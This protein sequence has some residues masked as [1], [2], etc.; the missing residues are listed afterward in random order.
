MGAKRQ[1]NHYNRIRNA[2][3]VDSHTL[4]SG[5]AEIETESIGR[6]EL[7]VC[8]IF[9][10]TKTICTNGWPLWSGTDSMSEWNSFISTF[11]IQDETILVV[12][13]VWW[14]STERWPSTTEWPK[15]KFEKCIAF[16][17]RAH[18]GLEK[19]SKRSS[20]LNRR[21]FGTILPRHCEMNRRTVANDFNDFTKHFHVSNCF[22]RLPFL[23]AAWTNLTCFQHISRRRIF[24]AMQ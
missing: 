21:D 24:S 9:N 22:V 3:A 20:T 17:K 11:H 19:R 16:A 18:N 10:F 1:W 23:F 13:T 5:P 12:C 7:A 6:H 8:R 4:L 2:D 14:V 15:E